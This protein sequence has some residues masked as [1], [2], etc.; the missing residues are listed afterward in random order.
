MNTVQM[1]HHSLLFFSCDFCLH[2][3]FTDEIAMHL[4]KCIDSIVCLFHN[5]V[6]FTME[7]F[8]RLKSLCLD[9]HFSDVG[10]NPSLSKN[11]CVDWIGLTVG[12]WCFHYLKDCSRAEILCSSE[13]KF[14][15]QEERFH[16]NYLNLST[17]TFLHF[18]YFPFQE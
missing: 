16:L 8:A 1:F 15:S 4:F 11:E 2:L 9:F 5:F 12:Y 10:S 6:T 17:F 18:F 14:N 3:S 7:S 13:Q